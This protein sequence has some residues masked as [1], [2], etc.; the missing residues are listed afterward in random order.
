MLYLAS[1]DRLNGQHGLQYNPWCIELNCFT[2]DERL[3]WSNFIFYAFYPS[4]CKKRSPSTPGCSFTTSL[5]GL[6]WNKNQPLHWVPDL[7]I[8]HTPAIFSF[9]FIPNLLNCLYLLNCF[10]F[11]FSGTFIFV[12][13]SFV[14]VVVTHVHPKVGFDLFM[15][16][17]LIVLVPVKSAPIYLCCSVDLSSLSGLNQE[18]VFMLLFCAHFAIMVIS[19][20]N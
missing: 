13:V 20:W 15:I 6:N 19:I 12:N 3:L 1:N 10:Y 2:F 16:Y 5:T 9:N 17:Y 7:T 14:K 11:Y 18:V 4:L 8:F